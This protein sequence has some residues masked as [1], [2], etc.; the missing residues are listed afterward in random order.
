MSD[1]RT[2]SLP[3]TGYFV[4]APDLL[5]HG[6][7]RRGSDYTI[8]TLAD[9]LR[10]YF[11]TGD[12][13]PYDIVIGHSLG[14]LVASVLF[15]LLKSTRPVRAVLVDPPFELTPESVV[16]A[17]AYICDSVRNPKTP[18]GYQREWPLC[19]KEDA[20]IASLSAHLCD[21]ATVEAIFDVRLL[22][23][24]DRVVLTWLV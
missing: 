16:I 12:D 8:S 15:P 24:Y 2:I 1:S 23:P 10:P 21:V 22:V 20:A 18:E 5:G 14:C 3:D 9:E 19:T 17:K 4:I 11:M 13:H 7:A 6:F